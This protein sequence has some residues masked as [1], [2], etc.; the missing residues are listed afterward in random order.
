MPLQ[1]NFGKAQ[2]I[3]KEK[4]R[5]EREPLF[6]ANDIKLQNAIADDDATAKAEAITER[7]RLRAITDQVDTMTTVEELKGASA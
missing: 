1:V 4:L 2:E 7:D 6:A 3:T 5:T